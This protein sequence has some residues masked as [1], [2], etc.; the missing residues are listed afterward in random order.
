MDIRIL[1]TPDQGIAQG[2]QGGGVGGGERGL[3]S[4]NKIPSLNIDDG[5][6]HSNHQKI[7]LCTFKTVLIIFKIL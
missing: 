6:S 5:E 2:E 3:F 4:V 1:F 7:H